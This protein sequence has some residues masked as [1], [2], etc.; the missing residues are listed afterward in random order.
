MRRFEPLLALAAALAG[1]AAGCASTPAPAVTESSTSS[2]K[3]AAS[4]PGPAAASG[5]AGAELAIAPDIADRV[6]QFPAT[7][8]DYDRAL[9]DERETSALRLL[10]EASRELDGIFLGQVAEEA[11]SMRER[12]ARL[13]SVHEPRSV[14]AIE[15]FDVMKGPWDRLKGDEPF[16]GSRR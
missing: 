6:R 13:V 5:A 12:V 1:F 4:A 8:I 16:V 7:K 9:L 2:P 3:T 10:I 14:P 15:Y 11:P